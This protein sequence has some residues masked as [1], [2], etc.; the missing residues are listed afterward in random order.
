M[1]ARPAYIRQTQKIKLGT[2]FFAT[3]RQNC[4][5]ESACDD[6]NDQLS[7]GARFTAT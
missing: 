2:K 4:P 5:V 1:L 7:L 6:N 3:V